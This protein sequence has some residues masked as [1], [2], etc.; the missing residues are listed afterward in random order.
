MKADLH[1]HS[2]ASDGTLTPE[3]LVELAVARGLAVLALT[4]HDSVE[5]VASAV[6]AA[7]GTGVTVVPAVEL[8]AVGPG[9]DDV[10]ILGYFIDP[11]DSRLRG[12]LAE[13]RTARES[14]AAAIVSALTQAGYSVDLSEV[15][16]LSG[17][18]AV[19]RS[20]VARALVTAGHAESVS[21]AFRTL[22]GRGRSFYVAKDVR[23]PQ[24]VISCIRDAGGF[25]VLAHPGA[26][27]VDDLI[28]PLIGW[29]LR[30]LE[31]FHG[32]HTR[33]QQERYAQVASE[34]GLL[35][36]GGSDFHGPSAPNAGLG[37]VAIPS[38][39]IEAFL[40]AGAHPR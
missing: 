25:A 8:S 38:E 29:G 3:A 17:G 30:G 36:T 34:L 12:H 28:Q 35:V 6:A 21:E 23:G 27:C 39:E 11:D 33:E 40:A 16:K 4:D 31:V 24:E 18:G 1:V 32:E 5:G 26:S 10:H 13:L 19:G 37:S 15:M 22:I 20:H 7:E 2:T 14:R 9:G